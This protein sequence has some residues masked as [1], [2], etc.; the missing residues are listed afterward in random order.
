VVAVPDLFAIV[1]GPS[2]LVV[3]GDVIFAHDLD[4]PAVEQIICTACT[5]S[6]NAGPK[7]NTS[8][9]RQSAR[10][11][12]PAPR[13]PVVTI[14]ALASFRVRRMAMAASW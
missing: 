2:S 4:A 9:S 5:C 8:T 11:G 14:G 3:D 1:V 7:S 13:D 10:P 12:R 6:G